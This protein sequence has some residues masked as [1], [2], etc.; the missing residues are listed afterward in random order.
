MS[1][2]V[3]VLQT[4]QVKPMRRRGVVLNWIVLG[5]VC[6]ISEESWEDDSDDGGG[7]SEGLVLLLDVEWR[8]WA[9]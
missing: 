9:M 5:D 8:R 6:F 1:L 3:R 2:W 4:L 7:G